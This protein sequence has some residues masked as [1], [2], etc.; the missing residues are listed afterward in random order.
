MIPQRGTFE[1]TPHKVKKYAGNWVAGKQRFY[2]DCDAAHEE[3]A[4][5][6]D[7]S[8]ASTLPA[9]ESL[10]SDIKVGRNVLEIV[11]AG[12]AGGL[13]YH[14]LAD[15]MQ[16]HVNTAKHYVNTAKE[17]AGTAKHYVNTAKEYAGT[18]KEYAG[19]AKKYAK[20]Y[21]GTVKHYVDKVW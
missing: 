8:S 17:Y 6:P 12:V 5:M 4:V 2:R 11:G 13:A 10:A 20:D 19:T 1:N 9:D 16:P 7:G 15:T 21:A 14:Y 3:Y 18:A